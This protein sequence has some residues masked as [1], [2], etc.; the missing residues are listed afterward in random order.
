[1]KRLWAVAA[2]AAAAA[3][4]LAS[5]LGW[6][7]AAP[8][9]LPALIASVVLAEVFRINLT[10]GRQTWSWSSSETAIAAALLLANGGW[11]VVGAMVGTVLVMGRARVAPVKIAYNAGAYGL[12][13]A[14][15]VVVTDLASSAIW[16][17]ALAIVVAFVVDHLL[18]SYAIARTSD[19]A[20]RE[21]FSH[22]LGASIWHVAGSGSIGILGAWLAVNAPLGILA[23]VVPMVTLW[24]A[25]QQQLRQSAETEMFAELAVGQERFAQHT[26]DT[27][28]RVLVTSTARLYNADVQLV[29]LHEETP[30]RYTGDENDATPV[31]DDSSVLDEPWVLAA[32]GTPG[33]VTGA[34]GRRPY[35]SALIGTPEAPLGVLHV[36]REE[37]APKFEKRDQMLADVLLKQAESWFSM[38]ELTEARD[39]AVERAEAATEAARALGDMGADTWPSLMRLRESASR[40]SRL[41]GSASGRESLADIVEEL[42]SAE[43]AVASLLGAVAMAADPELAAVAT[44]M[45]GEADLVEM[46]S[47]AAAVE[48]DWTTTGL[49]EVVEEGT[50]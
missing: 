30:L 46:P 1:M 47:Q 15:A 20:W 50:R 4:A 18:M 5:L 10:L 7:D 29:L 25:Q 43:R 12:A 28:A 34:E 9:A 24:Q 48:D 33:S 39:E 22:D 44:G 13:V 11:V 31:R 36:V 40:L 27:S 6:G 49:L 17:V 8:W 23:L 38:A 16:A 35:L 32:L 26:V 41:A 19:V 21:V 14:A 37:N 3:G 2:L 45:E 42:H